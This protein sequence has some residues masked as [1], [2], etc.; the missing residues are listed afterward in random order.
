MKP[1]ESGKRLLK[2]GRFS[3]ADRNGRASNGKRAAR[4]GS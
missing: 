3:R 1:R 4:H 2:G